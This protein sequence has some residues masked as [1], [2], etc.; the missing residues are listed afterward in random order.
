MTLQALSFCRDERTKEAEFEGCAS[1]KDVTL[2]V[3]IV[4]LHSTHHIVKNELFVFVVPFQKL[5][6]SSVCRRLEDITE[7]I[8]NIYNVQEERMDIVSAGDE[9]RVV[10]AL[11]YGS[12]QS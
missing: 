6:S 9:T 3:F 5:N 8:T 4:F 11:S 10:L 1:T 7:S 2:L 12:F